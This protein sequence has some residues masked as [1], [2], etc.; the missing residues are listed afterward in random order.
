MTMSNFPICARCNELVD[1]Y[2]IKWH[3]V[4]VRNGLARMEIKLTY[5][6]KKNVLCDKCV[7]AELYKLCKEL[8]NHGD[9]KYD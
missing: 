7:R 9:F 3:N 5:K 4:P 6:D 2:T 1:E 8:H